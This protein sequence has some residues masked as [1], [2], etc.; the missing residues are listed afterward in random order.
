VTPEQ[1]NDEAV[2][3]WYA[4]RR[5]RLADNLL[6]DRPAAMAAPGEL[7]ERLAAWAARLAAGAGQNLVLTGPVGAG[8]TW[9]I[10]KAAERAVQEGYEGRI[11]I[12]AAAQLRRCIAP[13][14]ADPREFAGYCT[15]GLLAIDDLA[16]FRLS[17]WD[18]DHLGELADARWN[19]QLPTII[20]SNKTNLAELLGPRISSRLQHNALRVP[21]DGPDRR[22]QP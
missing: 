7:D 4:E 12:T 10:W 6:R 16:T 17:E 9:A 8:K 18:L 11:I 22:R 2:A 14:T 15:A 13:A 3:L 19:A 20:T 21:L 5:Q 1:V